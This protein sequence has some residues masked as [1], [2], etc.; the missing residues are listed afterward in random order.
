MRVRLRLP[1]NEGGLL[2][3]IHRVGRVLEIHY[4]DNDILLVA[5]IP[6]VLEGKLKPFILTDVDPNTRNGG[7]RTAEGA[8]LE[9]GGGQS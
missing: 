3:D 4:E 8:S 2:S 9:A 1:Q 7:E 6:P 5:H